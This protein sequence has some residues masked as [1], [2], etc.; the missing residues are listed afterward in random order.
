MRID[1]DFAKERKNIQRHKFD[2]SFATFIFTDPLAV[3]V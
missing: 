3:T 1:E 2:F